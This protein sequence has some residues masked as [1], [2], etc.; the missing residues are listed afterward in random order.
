MTSRPHTPR[1]FGTS[2]TPQAVDVLDGRHTPAKS[3]SDNIT[4][5]YPEYWKNSGNAFRIRPNSAPS[6]R[7]SGVPS[8]AP[9]SIAAM[10]SMDDGVVTP[11]V[12]GVLDFGKLVPR[13]PR[14]LEGGG[15]EAN[16]PSAQ[17]TA[18]DP[19]LVA[20]P[21]ISPRTRGFSMSVAPAR[22][23]SRP[24]SAARSSDAEPQHP[25]PSAPPSA[26]RV[27]GFRFAAMTT[28]TQAN[29]AAGFG[30]A[31]TAAYYRHVLAESGA[32]PSAI[33]TNEDAEGYLQT[34]VDQQEH[35]FTV[36]LRG[37]TER[38]AKLTIRR[39]T[40]THSAGP[41]TMTDESS[42]QKNTVSWKKMRGRSDAAVASPRVSVSAAADAQRDYLSTTRHVPVVCMTRATSRAAPVSTV[43]PMQQSSTT[44]ASMRG[45]TAPQPT[46]S[47]RHVRSIDLAK[48]RPHDLLGC[49][50]SGRT[51]GA[52]SYRVQDDLVFRKAPSAIIV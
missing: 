36:G 47:A 31:P 48:L 17:M 19:F 20:A 3:D 2:H 24:S 6:M 15:A 35:Q 9:P 1:R 26:P 49:T 11:R 4:G 41:Y 38:R 51:S 12:R 22:A 18:A 32:P 14:R 43:L 44:P 16:V 28:R 29:Y 50:R 52:P 7:H 23:T 21:Q 42:S 40:Y 10:V 39:R 25:I 8:Q 5:L 45:P 30:E 33:A 27:A 34:F 37:A 46:S 13:S